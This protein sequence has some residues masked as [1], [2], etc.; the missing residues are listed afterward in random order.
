MDNRPD[1]LDAAVAGADELLD[2][3]EESEADF[4]SVDELDEVESDD[5]ELDVSA[6]LELAVVVFLP[7]SRLSVR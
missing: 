5:D 7:D 2:E 1:Q 4:F 3:L 6:P